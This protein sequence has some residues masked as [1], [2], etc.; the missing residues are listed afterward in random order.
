M[1]T[2]PAFLASAILSLVIPLVSSLPL[3]S[4]S[5]R[6]EQCPVH[7]PDDL[8][9]PRIVGGQSA[10][11]FLR[12]HMVSFYDEGCGGSLIASR[13]VLT[14]AHCLIEPSSM[15]YIGGSQSSDGTPIRVK[16]IHRHPDYVFPRNDILLIELEDDVPSPYNFMLLNANPSLPEEGEYARAVGYGYVHENE[17]GQPALRQVDIPIVTTQQCR[18]AY[19]A[20]GSDLAGGIFPDIHIC[21]GYEQGGC[22]SCSADSGGP[23]FVYDSHN[24]P[25]QIAIVSFGYGCARE[26]MPG[27]YTR[28]SEYIPWLKSLGADFTT[29]TS[30]KSVFMAG[31]G[32]TSAETPAAPSSSPSPI[33]LTPPPSPSPQPPSPPTS[34]PSTATTSPPSTTN[35]PSSP[36]SSSTTTGTGTEG[37]NTSGDGSSGPSTTGPTPPTRLPPGEAAGNPGPNPRPQQTNSPQSPDADE[38]VPDSPGVSGEPSIDETGGNS[39]LASA[40]VGDDD[41]VEPDGGTNVG[42]IVGGLFGGLALVALVV[43]AVFLG[44]RQISNAA[45]PAESAHAPE[46]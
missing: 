11:L 41:K 1:A 27:G 29:A 42:A 40:G 25:I 10:N 13:W 46:P 31:Y 4:T 33:P 20:K 34:P 32:S 6:S 36:P 18:A 15:A 17:S 12:T 43:A 39:G 44:K 28:V 16:A 3:L 35:N 38:P 8:T 7:L 24:N 21:A 5:V 9:S 37:S 19:K 14:A 26:G 22:D 45:I 23:L 2:L 30:R